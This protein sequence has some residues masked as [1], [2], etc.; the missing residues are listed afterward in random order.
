VLAI[1]LAP[2]MIERLG[3]RARGLPNLR[4]QV[5][6]GGHLG[7]LDNSFVV[8]ASVNGV[9]LFADVSAGIAEMVRVTKRAAGSLSSVSHTA[10]STRSSS[11]S[12]LRRYGSWYPMPRYLRR[13]RYRCR[14]NS[15]IRRSCGPRWSKPG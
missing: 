7:L 15:P 12:S 14:S 9:T 6:D 8:A 2:T 10:S 5:M 3:T 1:D 13:T 4:G 11:R